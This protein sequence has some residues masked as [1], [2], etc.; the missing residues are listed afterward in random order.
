MT[1][2]KS[3]EERERMMEDEQTVV[4]PQKKTRRMEREKYLSQKEQ[5][6]C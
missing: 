4:L 3:G 1:E 5:Q 2:G 6:Y